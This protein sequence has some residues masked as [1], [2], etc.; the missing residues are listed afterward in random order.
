[1]PDPSM[2]DPWAMEGMGTPLTSTENEY[3]AGLQADLKLKGVILASAA[4]DAGMTPTT[5]LRR[6]LVLGKIAATGFYAEYDPTKTN[7]QEY[8]VGILHDSVNMLDS[9]GAAAT[10][11]ARMCVW[12]FDIKTANVYGLDALA[13]RQM[14][15]R[16]WFDDG[17]TP[18]DL[19]TA[20]VVAKTADYT[21][22]AADNN[23]T[24]TNKGAGGA[25]NFTLPAL[26]RGL[27]FR[28]FVEADQTL[29]IT[30]VPSDSLVVFNDLAA[31]TIAYSTASEKIGGGFEVIAN[32]DATKWL[33]F[34]YLGIETQTPVITT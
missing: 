19:V 24:F 17:W 7:G 26:A 4:V 5:T 27:R 8:A 11:Q 22:V 28:F 23:K 30:S 9:S 2:I 15:G 10:K 6:G 34:V 31:D 29:T 13:R 12:G 32:S 1:M 3:F 21:V 20:L 14:S 33:V 16:I 18:P 25:V